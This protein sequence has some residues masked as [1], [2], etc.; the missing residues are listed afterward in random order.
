MKKIFVFILFLFVLFINV[1]P[2]NFCFATK[3]AKIEYSYSIFFE[4]KN[5]YF[6]DSDFLLNLSQVQKKN[7]HDISLIS[8]LEKLNLEKQE[9]VKYLFPE[10]EQIF[11]RL[12]KSIEK[13]EG[14]DAVQ[15]IPNSCKLN[16]LEG[17]SGKTINKLDF[18]NQIFEQVKVGDK[19]IKI[20]ANTLKYKTGISA[21]EMFK[22]K[23]CFS[24]NFSSS[25][26]ERK[27][28][29]KVAL[30]SLDGI[31]VDEGEILSFNEV[32]GNRTSETGYSQAKIISNGT[33]VLGFGGGV[34]QVSTTL[35]NS[36]LLAGLE[37]I[38]SNSHSLPASYVEPSFDSM[39][40]SGSSDLKIRN[41]SGGKII[42]TT[43]SKNDICKIKIYGLKNKYKITRQSEKI[44]VIAAEPEV[45]ETDYKKYGNYDLNVGE[46]KR[47]SYSKDGFVSRGYLNYYDE[48][49]NLVKRKLIRENTYNPTKGVILKR[50]K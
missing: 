34:C 40:N 27:N 20:Q 41:N 9:I 43:S 7:Y 15:V 49:G 16:I 25:S 35:Y 33:F 3:N 30:A 39:V 36:C 1:H 32:T 29:I 23:S 6:K 14:F 8:Y 37:I 5:F 18:Y 17:E 31:I 21:K 12:T 10:T 48:Q 28:N 44:K 13:K 42:I 26:P 19:T 22:Q 11:L 2:Q 24:T 38:E 45:V 47:L 50:E 4:N 46:E